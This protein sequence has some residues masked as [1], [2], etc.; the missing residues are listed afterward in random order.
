MKIRHDRIYHSEFHDDLRWEAAVHAY[1]LGFT[2][3]IHADCLWALYPHN[4]QVGCARLGLVND[5]II[6]E[7]EG[8]K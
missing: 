4:Y 8:E 3:M 6:D 7:E 5:L 1:E 2:M